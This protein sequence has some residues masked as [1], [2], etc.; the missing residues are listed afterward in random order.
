MGSA[1]KAAAGSLNC[2]SIIEPVRVAFRKL[3]H[4][5]NQSVESVQI[6]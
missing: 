6:P 3:G 4:E 2:E 1:A 5:S